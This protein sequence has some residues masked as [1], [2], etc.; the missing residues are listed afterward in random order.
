IRRLPPEPP[1][2]ARQLLAS[3]IDLFRAVKVAE[4]HPT[5]DRFL[6]QME[7]TGPYQ[8]ALKEVKW[9]E[10][11]LVGR[12]VLTFAPQSVIQLR[13]MGA[14]PLGDS[15]RFVDATSDAGL[16]DPEAIPAARRASQPAPPGT[17]TALAT[18]DFNGDGADEV[19]ATFWVPEQHKYV[20]R[21]YFV[22]RF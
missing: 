7:L 5:F 6:N 11:P 3:S 21:L 2:E 19:F 9:V 18:G 22:E 14:L 16:P 20:S 12:T 17:Q 8:A 1:E 13:G 4:A 15:T 10:G